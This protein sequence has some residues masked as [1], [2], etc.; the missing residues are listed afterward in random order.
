MKREDVLPEARQVCARLREAGH[1]AW[2]VGGCV[3]DTLLGRGAKDWDVAT[4]ARPEEVQRLF[5]R[6]I[7]TGIQHGTVT[8]LLKDVPI[9]TTTFRGEGAYSDARRPDSVTFGVP[10]RED[11]ARR[12]FTMNAIAFDPETESFA[13]PF[14]GEKDLRAK[15]IRAVGDASARFQ[16]DGLRIMRALRFA[17]VLEFTIDPETE[18]GMRAALPSLSRV[19]AERVHD[20]LVKLMAA[21][22]PSIG[23]EIAKRTG[24]VEVILPELVPAIGM[25][26]NRYHSYDVWDHTLAT[27]DATP[28]D[29][30]CRLGALLHDVGKPRTAAPK[31]DAPGENSFYRHDLV[32]AEMTDEIMRRLKFSNKDRERVVGIVAHHMFWYSPEWSDATVRRF[33]K[34]VGEPLLPDL[35]AVRQGDVAGRGRG[36][37][38]EVELAELRQ[39]VAK[40]L[41]EDAALST[42]D[43]AISGR[44]VMQALGIP[45]GRVIGDLLAALLEK[46][47]DDPAL[48][49]RET[50]LRLL[51]ELWA[52]KQG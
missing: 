9:E 29:P 17:A 31:P 45:P 36:E 13:D 12:D 3:R 35:F 40:V 52:S 1:E 19:S 25:V 38:P 24:V 46:V 26:Q 6:T 22:K 16:E 49:E 41:A 20:E 11:L 14:E 23:L 32:G 28:G 8:V 18:A 50:L 21:R 47:I 39:R 5:R 48:N 43:L 27:V 2:I 42:S 15:L 4:S 51:G 37:D 30:I 44:D 33:V 7:P 34:R 10:L